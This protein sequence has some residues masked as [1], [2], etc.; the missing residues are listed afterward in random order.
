MKSLLEE[1]KEFINRGNIV[2]LAVAFIIGLQIK[3][4]I[5]SL[6]ADVIM[7]IVGAVV[8]KPSFADLKFDLGDGVVTYGAF[9]TV[10]V[11]FL[12]I[13]FVVFLL[14][15]AYQGLLD[16]VRKPAEAAAEEPD[17]KQLLTEIR[18]LLAQRRD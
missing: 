17:E 1:F 6:V 14:V 5:D 2:E 10:V 3:Q 18:D 12:I 9:L 16:K 13:A 15:K 7:P 11:N 8:G 4:V